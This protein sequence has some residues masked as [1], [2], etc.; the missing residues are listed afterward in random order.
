MHEAVGPFPSITELATSHCPNRKHLGFLVAEGHVEPEASRPAPV[1]NVNIDG[2]GSSKTRNGYRDLEDG[3][4]R[5]TVSA[6][7]T[8][9]DLVVWRASLLLLFNA[10]KHG[11]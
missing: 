2:S 11:L 7:L 6:S 10:P 5:P 4:A 1:R 8:T 9:H 3:L